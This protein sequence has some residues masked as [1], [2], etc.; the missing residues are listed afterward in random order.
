MELAGDWLTARW[1]H[2]I[3]CS[4]RTTARGGPLGWDRKCCWGLDRHSV[5][6]SSNQTTEMPFRIYNSFNFPTILFVITNKK[7][8]SLE[9]TYFSSK[10]HLNSESQFFSIRRQKL[11]QKKK[12]E[13]YVACSFLEVLFNFRLLKFLY[14]AKMLLSQF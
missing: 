3:D 4:A 10:W 13:I 1:R 5:R 2:C 9:C 8:K 6:Y 11:I 7:K 14:M 12:C